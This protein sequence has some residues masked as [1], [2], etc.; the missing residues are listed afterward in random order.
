LSTTLVPGS[1]R[2]LFLG[3]QD[4]FVYAVDADT[5]QIQWTSQTR[6]GTEGVQGAPAAMLVAAGGNV[7]QVL[8]GTRDTSAAGN[9][10]YA[11]DIPTGNI[12][13]SFAP[14][15]PN[16][17]VINSGAALDYPGRRVYFSSQ[18][19]GAGFTLW[20]LAVGVGGVTETCPGWTHQGIGNVDSGPVFRS[21][22]IYVGNNNGRVHAFNDV[23]SEMWHFD[24]GDGAVKGFVFP[25]PFGPNLYFTTNNKVWGIRDDGG[26]ATQLWPAVTVD[27]VSI[28]LFVPGTTKVIVGGEI[29]GV[30][31]LVQLELA[32]AGMPATPPTVASVTLGD[33]SAVVGSAS[34]DSAFG[35][36]YVGTDAGVIYAVQVPF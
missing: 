11:L 17:G 14:S 35:M 25:D 30:R 8:V 15:G 36:V 6:L 5:G 1:T 2:I 18:T 19:G 34:Y 9:L 12:V 16:M 33:A 26:F 4:G 24:T 3:A 21:G 7:N 31:Q 29:A 23:G 32:G 20:C 28:V 13:N 27:N 10:F 22:R